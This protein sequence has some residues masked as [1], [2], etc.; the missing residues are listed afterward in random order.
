[1]P[2]SKRASAESEAI[3]IPVFEPAGAPPKINLRTKSI[4]GKIQAQAQA[5]LGDVQIDEATLSA[6]LNAA[7]AITKAVRDKIK[8]AKLDSIA[9]QL[10]VAATGKVGFLG[11]GLD[12]QASAAI[13][14]SFKF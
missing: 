2:K 4:V 9:F 3:V 5:A 6:C 12:V 8:E 1:M 13:Q 10:G 14:L 7:D 11:T